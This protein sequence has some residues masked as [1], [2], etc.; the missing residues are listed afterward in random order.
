MMKFASVVG[1]GLALFGAAQIAN[2]HGVWVAQRWDEYGIIYGH[3]AE[4]NDY[5]PAKIK[6][7]TVLTEDGKVSEGK[8]ETRD[9]HAMIVPG[10]DAAIVLIDFDNGFYTEGPDGKWVNQPKSAVEGAKQAGHYLKHSVSLL[11]IHG[12]IPALPAQPLQIV[13]LSNPTELEAGD[14]FKVRVLYEGKPLPGVAIIPDYVNLAE[15]LIGETDQDGV[16]DIT[17]RNDGLNVIAVKHSVSL[18]NN[19]DADLIQHFATLSFTAG[20]E[21][22]H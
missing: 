11:H 4:D 22:S 6:S 1:V 8:V 18:E 14:D 20:G 13:P 16:A 17:V 5:D 7:V 19:A 9:T 15:T 2:A 12:D 21:H 10:E 3:G